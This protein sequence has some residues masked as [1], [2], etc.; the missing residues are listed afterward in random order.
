VHLVRLEQ[1]SR[2]IF[3]QHFCIVLQSVL[4]E[5]Y[6]FTLVREQDRC[7]GFLIIAVITR[8][9]NFDPWLLVSVVTRKS[10]SDTI[11]GGTGSEIDSNNVGKLGVFN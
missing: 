1:Q 8:V 7:G 3:I 6:K 4:S 5:G 10:W 11:S 2:L 9:Q